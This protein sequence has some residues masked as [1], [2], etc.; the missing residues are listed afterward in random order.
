MMPQQQMN[1]AQNNNTQSAAQY[2]PDVFEY[3][4]ELPEGEFGER[5]ILSDDPIPREIG[6][7]KTIG[8]KKNALNVDPEELFD[9]N[10]DDNEDDVRIEE[11]LQS[12]M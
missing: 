12:Q 3:D 5:V 6:V 11:F 8:T 10:E 9:W 1:F 2:D 4:D 7:V